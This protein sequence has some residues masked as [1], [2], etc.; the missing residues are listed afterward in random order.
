M[1]RAST[2]RTRILRFRVDVAVNVD[3][4]LMLDRLVLRQY[5]G[6]MQRLGVAAKFVGHNHINILRNVL[7]DVLR[8]RSRLHIFGMEEAQPPPRCRMPMT[9]SF[10][11]SGWPAF[12]LVAALPSADERLVYLKRSAKRL[13]I[14]GLHRVPNPMAEI[15]C[16][17]VV[18][19]QHP[20]KLIGGHSLAR[21]AN[22]ERRKEPLNQRQMRVM[23]HRLCRNRE[24]VAA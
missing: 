22:Q 20:F 11:H 19:A 10:L 5:S 15:P 6:I 3:A 9:T 12:M 24:L 17:A 14:D 18:D 16:C 1:I 2:A 4:I 13:R 7:S 8:Q 23:E 21:L